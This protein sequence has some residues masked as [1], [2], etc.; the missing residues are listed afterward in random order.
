MLIADHGG[1]RCGLQAHR[2]SSSGRQAGNQALS[3]PETAKGARRTT[4]SGQASKYGAA[5]R[6]QLSSSTAMDR[7]QSAEA[8]SA[9]NRNDRVCPIGGSGL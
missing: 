3:Q 9:Q 7:R 1:Y 4:P 2:A 6:R 5:S 8:A